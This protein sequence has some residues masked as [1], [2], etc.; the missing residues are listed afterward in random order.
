[1]IAGMVLAVAVTA[2]SVW[3][4]AH[5][6]LVGQYDVVGWHVQGPDVYRL[7]GPACAIGLALLVLAAVERNLALLVVAVIYLVIALVP[8][9]FGWTIT[10]PSRWGFVPHL[11]IPGSVLLAAAIGFAA[12]QRP[13]GRGAA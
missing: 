9:D 4:A 2:A 12:A 3:A 10:G 8:I 6:P 7:I 5:K 1:V 13:A 11:I